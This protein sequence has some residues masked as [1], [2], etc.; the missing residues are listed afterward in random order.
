MVAPLRDIRVLV[1]ARNTIAHP[2]PGG[3]ESVLQVLTAGLAQNGIRLALVTTPVAS[4]LE[5]DVRS[6]LGQF[7]QVWFVPGARSGRYS[8][9]WW[10]AT[11][12]NGAW[13]AWQPEV[14][15]SVGDAGGQWSRRRSSVPLV[16]QCHGT[17]LM[18][19]A[20]ALQGR[21]VRDAARAMLNVARIPSRALALD[22]ASEIWAISPR[23]QASVARITLG[24][25]VARFM[26][27][28]IDSSAYQPRRTER[29]PSGRERHA[30]YLGRLD[31]QKGIDTA[32]HA[33][34]ESSGL[35][36]TVVGDGR[37]RRRLEQLS[38]QLKVT[39]RVLFTGQLGAPEVRS[40]L[41]RADVMLLPTRRK[42]G[43]PMVLLEAAAA[44]VPAVTTP[45]ASVP[46][47]ILATGRV[48][49]VPERDR[50][51]LIE[52]TVRAI[53]LPADP[54]L[55]ARYESDRYIADHVDALRNLANKAK[56]K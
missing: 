49:V 41:Q 28:G 56:K 30:L 9:V 42:E 38:R 3:M 40:E 4:G 18:E 2:S 6:R 47:D 16:I 21:G 15:L 39:E 22:S 29:R 52:A 32:I 13:D 25:A 53:E 43:L 20:S 45:S 19:A 46:E 12:N 10:H 26:P 50:R 5:A 23:V 44:G 27:N 37:D 36:L 11:R 51:A 8:R 48:A 24:R 34:A 33:V 55:P 1:F 35:S 54:Y 7:E 17:P 14:V 31:P